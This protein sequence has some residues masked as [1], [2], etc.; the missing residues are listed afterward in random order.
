[1][2]QPLDL[3]RFGLCQFGPIE[4]RGGLAHSVPR[5]Q[6]CGLLCP[7]R[8]RSFPNRI[9]QPLQFPD[10]RGVFLRSVNRTRCPARRHEHPGQRIVIL[11]R[12]GIEFVIVASST[13]DGHCEK[14]F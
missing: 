4:F 2:Q 7:Q 6:F 13:G 3:A 14:R 8:C 9:T 5:R 10:R 12:N 1:M 11:L